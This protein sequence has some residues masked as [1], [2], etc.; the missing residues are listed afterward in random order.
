MPAPTRDPYDV[1]G[2]DRKA[3]GPEIKAAYRRLAMQYHPDRNAGDR[4]AEERFKEVSLAYALL[5]D[6]ERRA[7]YD[8]FGTVAGEAPFGG[9]ATI[10]RATEFFESIFGDLF[11]FGR[12][13]AAGQD[14]RYTLEVGFEEAALGC[15]RE[16]RF[17]RQ[18]DCGACSGAGAVGG[19]AGLISCGACGGQGV[20]RARAGFFSA[21][22]DCTACGG[23][24]EVPRERC[25]ACA[26]T[27][28]VERERAYTVRIPPGSQAGTTQRVPGEGAPGRRGGPAGD[29]FVT[30]R[31][32]LQELFRD[33]GGVLTLE[34][35][36]S[37]TEAALG[38]DVEVPTLDGA[39]RMRVPPGTQSG[40]VFRLKGKGI[41]R[42]DGLPRGDAHVRVV[43]ETPGAASP[44]AAALL[45]RLE[46]ALGPEA[47]SRRAAVRAA[48]AARSPRAAAA[49]GPGP[50]PGATKDR[51]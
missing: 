38:A 29:L 8:R 34:L 7:H 35:P 46:A 28:L 17:M 15:A 4:A 19:A 18:E 5:G 40:A 48:V 24:G 37:I 11:G 25:P 36:V 10:D 51:S 21:R 12:K 22:R 41:P 3:T 44:E 50:D 9:D 6:D 32:K 16:I 43:V 30:V 42:G 23:T 31:V 26:G 47:L 2:V 1:L 39:V 13:K 49:P 20:L 33:E 45:E 27:G 14:L